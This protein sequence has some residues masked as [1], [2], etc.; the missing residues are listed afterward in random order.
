MDTARIDQIRKLLEHNPGLRIETNMGQYLRDQLDQPDSP[1]HVDVLGADSRTG[2][3]RR[4]TVDLAD[5]R[6]QLLA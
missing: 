3:P 6:R 5:M 2:V 4:A 1:A